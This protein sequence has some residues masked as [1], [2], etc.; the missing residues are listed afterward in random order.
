[1]AVVGVDFGNLNCYISVARQGGIETVA[2]D[3][4]QRDTP[5]VVGFSNNQRIMGVGAKN[6]LLTNLKRTVFNFKHML[7]RKFKD[8]YVQ[9]VMKGLPYVIGELILLFFE[10]SLKLF[11]S[12]VLLV[13]SRISKISSL[14]LP[15]LFSN[16]DKLYTVFTEF[17]FSFNI[18][19]GSHGEIRIQLQYMGKDRAYTPEEITAMLL[20]KL[21]ETAEEALKTKVKDIVISGMI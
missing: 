19:E 2:N 12:I 18:G 20:T 8:P 3:Y 17:F 10:I 11:H 9:E 6:Q 4:S 7:G 5:S 1:M 16:P 21:K 13:I 15:D 14:T